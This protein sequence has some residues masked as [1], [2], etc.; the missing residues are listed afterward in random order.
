MPCPQT[1]AGLA[2]DCTPSMGGIKEVY[3]ANF[4]DVTAITETS[5]KISAITMAAGTGSTTAKF[6]VYR[7]PRN[8][9]SMSSNF[10]IDAT[11]G[12]NFVVTDLVLQFNRM[13]TAKRVEI[14]ALA[15]GDLR[16]IV[17]DM[18][19]TYWLLGQEEPVSASAGDGLSG[20]QRSD[21]NGYSITLQENSKH[22]PVEILVGTSGVD[23]S[24]IVDGL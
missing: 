2:K 17:R 7:F 8:T 3:I 22:L 10:T 13:E 5:N 18:N 12:A 24:T 1:L 15:Q 4:D 20:T 14:A 16:V 21:R 6:K 11:T 19:D 23:L 9:G